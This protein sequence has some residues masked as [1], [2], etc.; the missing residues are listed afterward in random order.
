MGKGLEIYISPKM[1]Y[2]PTNYW[3]HGS[4]IKEL[5]IAQALQ[6]DKRV[7]TKLDLREGKKYQKR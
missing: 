2:K 5:F 7:M 4:V 3:L 1:I 6:E